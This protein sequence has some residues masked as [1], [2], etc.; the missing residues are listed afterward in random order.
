MKNR[1]LLFVIWLGITSCTTGKNEHEVIELP[2]FNHADFTPEWIEKS[3]KRYD[4]IHTIA[5]FNLTDQNGVQITNEALEG[6]IYVSNFFFTICPGICP[7]MTEN[8][9]EVQKAFIDDLSVKILSHTVM[10]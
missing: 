2:F 4:S 7:R 9:M 6:K 1:F 5:P 10:S 3:S 8:L